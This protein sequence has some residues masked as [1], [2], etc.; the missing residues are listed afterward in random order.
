M[1]DTCLCTQQ[2]HTNRAASVAMIK[3]TNI[4]TPNG[5]GVNDTWKVPD[6]ELF[7][8]N[9]VKVFDRGGRQ[10]FYKKGYTNDWDGSLSGNPLAEGT[11]YYV[12]YLGKDLNMIYGYI[13]I[14]R[15]R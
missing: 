10:V 14:L 2:I 15:N 6:I 11:Y 3:P 13:T 4:L 9:Y 1:P 5:D 12:V 8:D 7:P